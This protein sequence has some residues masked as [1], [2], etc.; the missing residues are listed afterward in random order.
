MT[1][2]EQLGRPASP[3]LEGPLFD[4]PRWYRSRIRRLGP[5][6]GV[7]PMALVGAVAWVALRLGDGRTSGM[8]GL[9]AG[10]TA[11]PGLLVAGAPF[12]DSDGYPVA[13]LASVPLW[14]ALGFVASRRATRSPIA[15]W[16]A[17]TRELVLLTIAVA[18][19]AGAALG[20]SALS[21]GESL[22]G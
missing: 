11:A 6:F 18:I 9:V 7:L 12:S 2:H 22:L 20:V 15:T 1:R 5:L 13:V 3:G 10:V 19:G 4:G 14:I 17:Y 21:L 8:L 16:G